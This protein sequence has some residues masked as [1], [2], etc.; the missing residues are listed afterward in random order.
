MADLILVD[1]SGDL[2]RN[3]TRFFIMTAIVTTR[4]RN[5][6]A[7]SK[8]LP[9][10]RGEVKFH[11]SDDE[12]RI[13]IMR[14]LS[15]APETQMVCACCEKKNQGDRSLYGNELYEATLIDLL[16]CAMEVSRRRDISVIIDG[17]RFITNRRLR[18]VTDSLGEIHHKNVKKCRKGISQN[19]LCIQVADYVAGSVWTEYEKDDNRFSEIIREKMTVARRY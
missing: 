8:L 16:G 11:D 17:N 13:E 4:S 15:L 6:L 2:G 18:E 5:L 19:E 12:S 9:Q 3:G 14:C 10:G 1:E 7:T